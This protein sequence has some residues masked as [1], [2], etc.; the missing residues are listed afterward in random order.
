MGIFKLVNL[1]V[2]WLLLS[3]LYENES[4]KKS[5]VKLVDFD[6]PNVAGDD[7]KIWLKFPFL[8]YAEKL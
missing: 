5:V 8:A 7:V 6:A 1:L 2:L 4:K 3:F